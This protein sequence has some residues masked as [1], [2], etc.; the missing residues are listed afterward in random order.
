MNEIVESTLS[1]LPGLILQDSPSGPSSRHVSLIRSITALTSRQVEIVR[2]KAILALY[3]FYLIAPTQIQHIHEKF[4][5]A[6]CD[7]DAGVMA[8]SLH[9]YYEVIQDNPAGYKDLAG[10]LITILKQVVGGNLPADFYYHSVPAPWL[11][12]QLLRILRLLGKDDPRSH[13]S[14]DVV[15]CMPCIRFD[16]EKEDRPL[17][18]YAVQSYLAL[19]ETKNAHY[20]QRFLQ[21]ISWVL[22]EYAYLAKH[23]SVE[24]VM[25]N[26]YDVLKQ[27]SI[28]S[29]TKAWIVAAI[30]K[31]AALSPHCSLDD[32][33]IQKFST[34]LDTVMRQHVSKLKLLRA[35]GPLMQKLFPINSSSLNLQLYGLCFSPSLPSVSLSDG[36]SPSAVSVLSGISGNSEETGQ[37]EGYLLKKEGTKVKQK[38]ISVPLDSEVSLSG[39][40]KSQR[41]DESLAP[42]T[43]EE[44]EKRQLA[45]TLFVG[46]GSNAVSLMGKAEQTPKKFKRKSKI[47]GN[48]VMN[49]ESSSLPSYL[50]SDREGFTTPT[51]DLHLM[52]S[53]LLDSHTSAERLVAL[54]ERGTCSVSHVPSLLPDLAQYPHSPVKESASYE[55][56]SAYYS[57]VWKEDGL[58]LSIIVVN[59]TS[60]GIQNISVNFDD[61]KN[62]TV[63]VMG[64]TFSVDFFLVNFIRPLSISIEEFGKMWPSYSSEVKHKITVVSGQQSLAGVLHTLQQG[65]NLYIV[66]IIGDEGLAACQMLPSVPLLLHCHFSS[67]LVTLWIRSISSTLPDCLFYHCQ[68]AFEEQ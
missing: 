18:F 17:R 40:K 58:L 62:C 46:L 2:R 53:R 16:D 8:A 64:L 55:T 42:I 67:G 51:F 27:S 30:T 10:S 29:E 56:L 54:Q 25:S 6:L 26:L 24:S 66:E 19:L 5:K 7:R 20:P 3:K 59:R 52:N 44:K 49:E 48:K 22:G 4:R 21:V 34:C 13:T 43:E 45:S 23:I 50:S 35:D 14:I 47:S 31:L 36:H 63:T 9:I 39:D 33:L 68:K 11:Q 41:T 60:S 28:T 32:R 57:K 12:I 1:A 15:T 61:S 37:K 65:I 38:S